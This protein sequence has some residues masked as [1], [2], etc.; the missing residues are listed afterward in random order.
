MNRFC[1]TFELLPGTIARY[2]RE[3][4]EIWP[5]VVEGMH[6]A[7]ITTYSLFRRDY[8]VIAYGECAGP[9]AE[10][11]AQL[12]ADSANQRWSAHIRTLMHNPLAD[13]GELFFAP[14]VWRMT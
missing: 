9:I 5:S 2:D 3:H 10:A 8:L 4:S 7:G 13:N 1:Y 11:F 14:E 12:N 6:K